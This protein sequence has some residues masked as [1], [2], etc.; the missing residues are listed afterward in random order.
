MGLKLSC[1]KGFK[2]CVSSSSS[3]QDE[4]SPVLGDK[5]LTVPNIIVTP[6]TPT[7]M[8]LPRD[9]RQTVCLDEVVSWSDDGEA[10][11]DA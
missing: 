10:E 8:T 5:N 2:M 3:S 9:K 1:L 11:P 4:A 6:P 7:S